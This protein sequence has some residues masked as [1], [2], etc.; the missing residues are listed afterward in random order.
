MKSGK[1]I[2]KLYRNNRRNCKYFRRVKNSTNDDLEVLKGLENNDINFSLLFSVKYDDSIADFLQQHQ[3][4]KISLVF[5]V[6][7]Q[8]NSCSFS[9]FCN[10]NRGC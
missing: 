1:I 8:S 4:V 5:S 3:V 10:F 6:T 2:S 9:N 7:K